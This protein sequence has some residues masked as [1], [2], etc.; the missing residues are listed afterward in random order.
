MTTVAMPYII[1]GCSWWLKHFH[2]RSCGR[3]Q[4]VIQSTQLNPLR[5]IS[6]ICLP[7]PDEGPQ[8]IPSISEASSL[9]SVGVG[10]EAPSVKETFK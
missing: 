6:Q 5:A 4:N 2:A 10:A 7:P 3:G 8:Y 9:F 1:P